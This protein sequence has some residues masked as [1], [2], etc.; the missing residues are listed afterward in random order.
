MTA[1]PFIYD[2]AF[3]ISVS[4]VANAQTDVLGGLIT[5]ST[6]GTYICKMTNKTNTAMA[7]SDIALTA[8]SAPTDADI[9]QPGFT[10]EPGG[11]AHLKG[12]PLGSGSALFIQASGTL[13]V[14]V[15]GMK[16]A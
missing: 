7:V 14:T 6:A 16:G 8:G 15:A 4:L 12:L 10:I 2:R 9:I 11:W 3:K 5:D 1:P 13:S